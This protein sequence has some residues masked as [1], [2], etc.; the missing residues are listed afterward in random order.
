[1]NE[2]TL[3]TEALKKQGDVRVAFLDK[4][5]NDDAELRQRVEA[6]LRAGDHPD[7][8]LDAPAPVA[9][10]TIDARAFCPQAIQASIP[11]FCCSGVAFII[12]SNDDAGAL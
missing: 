3:F 2:E 10:S 6:L 9:G 4:H 1:M 5:C 8:F 11:A 12:C 7:P